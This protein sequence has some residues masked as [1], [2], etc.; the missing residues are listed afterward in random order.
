MKQMTEA[1]VW[2]A[3]VELNSTKKNKAKLLLSEENRKR[4]GN[5][6]FL[7]S[8]ENQTDYA[9][10]KCSSVFLQIALLFILHLL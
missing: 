7:S 5:S 10:V 8:N 1:N 2:D 3:E 6:L 9:S 4:R